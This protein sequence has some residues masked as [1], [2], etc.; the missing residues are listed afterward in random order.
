MLASN[1]QGALASHHG[2]NTSLDSGRSRSKRSTLKLQN[3][4]QHQT[5]HRIVPRQ[6]MM[7][8]VMRFGDVVLAC[9]LLAAT[10]PLMM[11]VAIAIKL[12]SRGAILDQET[13]SE[14]SRRYCILKFCTTEYAPHLIPP[15]W[16]QRPTQ[17]GRFLRHTRIEALP[18]LINVMR[19]DMSILDPGGSR[20]S[21]LD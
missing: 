3:M 5:V 6:S 17:I 2:H 4:R 12:Q 13:R 15:P 14:G 7:Q 18:Q 21:F 8:R 9:L 10:L 20:P 11:L 19:G 16:T 1:L